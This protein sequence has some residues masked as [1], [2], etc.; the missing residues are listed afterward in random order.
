ML[1]TRTKISKLR[2]PRV[3]ARTELQTAAAESSR[4][5]S[6]ALRQTRAEP[7]SPPYIFC[8][9][10]LLHLTLATLRADVLMI[11][12]ICSK[13]GVPR[14]YVRYPASA[15]TD[16]QNDIYCAVTPVP[17]NRVPFSF[18]ILVPGPRDCAR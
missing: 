4:A 13:P 3:T 7:T 10:P 1:S 11:D 17:I 15:I 12:R 8:T 5:H 2:Q 14:T 9:G 16:K 6:I 18:V